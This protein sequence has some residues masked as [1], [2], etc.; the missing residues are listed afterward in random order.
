MLNHRKYQ[1]AY[2]LSGYSIECAL[3]ACIA[4]KTKRYEFP[5]KRE[6]EACYTHKLSNL[7]KIAELEQVLNDMDGSITNLP[8]NWMVVKDW[9]ETS[10]YEKR[11]REDAKDIYIA[12]T[13]PSG[14]V[15]PWIR[16][17]W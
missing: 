14:G 12:I 2:Y 13:E 15:L 4:K 7:L 10:R 6:V 16:Q 5:D 9:T 8:S 11:S 3:K 17:Y 1:G